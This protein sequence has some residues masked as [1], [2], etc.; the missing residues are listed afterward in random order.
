MA[1]LGALCEA[2]A[3]IGEDP[4]T[5]LAPDTAHVVAHGHQIVSRQSIAGVRLDAHGD[6]QG[7]HALLD[8]E[9]GAR[10]EK[11]IHLCFGLFERFGVQNVDLV[12][13]MG[14]GAHATVWSHCLFTFPQAARHTMTARIELGT[15]AQ[16]TSNETHYHGLSGLIEV[17]PHARIRVG[18][19]ARYCADFALV[20]G[21][22]GK[23]DID[24]AVTVAEGGVAELTSKVYGHVS[25]KIRIREAVSLDGAGA[26]GL[27]KTR[28]A[29]EDQASA[30]IVG[31]TY[32]NAAGARGHVDCMEIVRGQATARAVPEVRVSHPEAKVTHE[33]AIG[34]VDARQLETL[35][36]RGLAPDDAVDRIVLGMLR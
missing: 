11:P 7:V 30:E 18:P 6:D 32:G 20:Q 23:L 21:R 15:E 26:R 28:V 27:V 17:I 10:I 24:Y 29:V 34:S 19:H 2:F 22:V 12:L 9:P 14:A 4:A 36:A 31:A 16:L 5:V 33:A 1:D 8:I 25:D 35:M 3:L 13:T